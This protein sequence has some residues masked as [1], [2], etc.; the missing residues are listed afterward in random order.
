MQLKLS[1][2]LEEELLIS[3]TFSRNLR[4]PIAW[5]AVE[6][7][8]AAPRRAKLVAQLKEGFR[9]VRPGYSLAQAGSQRARP[10]VEQERKPWLKLKMS[11]KMESN[12]SLPNHRGILT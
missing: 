2:S 4:R 1:R 6:E 10:Q 12:L 3:R 8:P 11:S 9:Q 7:L 5:Q